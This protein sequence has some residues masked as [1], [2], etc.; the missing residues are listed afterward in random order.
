MPNVV[1]AP[2]PVPLLLWGPRDE[3]HINPQHPAAWPARLIYVLAVPA[4]IVR[5]AAEIAYSWWI[6]RQERAVLRR[7]GLL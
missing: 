5:N 4:F 7:R 1:T 2:Q 6:S 3:V